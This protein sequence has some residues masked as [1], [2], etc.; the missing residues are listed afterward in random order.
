ME[1]ATLVRV[2]TKEVGARRFNAITVVLA[3]LHL[4]CDWTN[5]RQLRLAKRLADSHGAVFQV[6]PALQER[7]DGELHRPSAARG[8]KSTRAEAKGQP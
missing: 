2:H 8:A 5:P 1:Q 6:D 7:V 3:D 4:S